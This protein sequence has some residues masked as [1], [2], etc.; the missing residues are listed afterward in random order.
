MLSG[1]RL[2]NISSLQHGTNVQCVLQFILLLVNQC[3]GIAKEALACPQR[4]TTNKIPDQ[5]N[6]NELCEK[7]RKD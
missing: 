1:F 3:P 6:P 7:D 5:K 2:H 4:K